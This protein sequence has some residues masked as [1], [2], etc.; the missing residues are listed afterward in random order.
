M[1]LQ[2]GESFFYYYETA[3]VIIDIIALHYS[4]SNLIIFNSNLI[5]ILKL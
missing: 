4:L 2:A 3:K 1:I 5:F